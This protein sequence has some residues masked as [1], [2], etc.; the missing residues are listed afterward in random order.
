MPRAVDRTARLTAVGDAV[1][2]IATETGFT[3][4]TIRSVAERIGASTSAVTHYVGSRDE[5]LR[6]AVRRE[7]QVRRSQAEAAMAGRHG[8]VALRALVEWAVLTADEA[9]HRFWLALIVGAPNEP[10][11]RAELDA[12]NDWWDTHI[13]NMVEQTGITEVQ[14]AADLLNVVVDGL[15]IGAFDDGTPWPRAR[16]LQVLDATWRAIGIAE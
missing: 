6:I 12:F 15:V 9:T 1:V 14:H 11:L 10:I 2:T 5:M 13:R 16:R 8:A 7:V 4:V 3:A